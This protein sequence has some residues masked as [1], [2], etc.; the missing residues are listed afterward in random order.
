MKKKIITIKL[1]P[2]QKQQIEAEARRQAAI[3]SGVPN[4]RHQVY[5]S[6]KKYNR[7]NNKYY[8]IDSY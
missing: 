2:E 1:T 7:K 4:Y 6:K 5:S 8:G 3:E